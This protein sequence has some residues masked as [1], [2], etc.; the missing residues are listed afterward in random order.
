RQRR[1]PRP[2]FFPYTTLFRSQY[3]GRIVQQMQAL[4]LSCDWD[5]LR[6][7]MDD[8]LVRAVRVAFVRLYDEG[9]IYRGERIINWCPRDTTALSDR[10]STRLNSSHRTISYAV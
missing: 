10:K 1:H 9:V 7:T 5:R 3:G 4:G 2:P 8:G 6:F